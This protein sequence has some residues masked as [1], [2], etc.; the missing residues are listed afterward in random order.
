MV[1]DKPRANDKVGFAAHEREEIIRGIFAE[2]G[3]SPRDH[4]EAKER[5]QGGK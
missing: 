5:I 2:N 1:A 3:K 4:S